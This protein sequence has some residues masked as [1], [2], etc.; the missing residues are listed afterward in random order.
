MPFH[1]L[2]Y[3]YTVK[4]LTY[5][6]GAGCQGNVT[7]QFY[8]HM[9][10]NQGNWVGEGTYTSVLING[11]EMEPKEREMGVGGNQHQWGYGGNRHQCLVQH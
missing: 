2:S 10:I 11:T 3:I 6:L 9:S 1:P 8:Y 5:I 7:L 4:F